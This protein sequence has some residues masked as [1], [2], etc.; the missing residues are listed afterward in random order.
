MISSRNARAAP[1]GSSLNII[2][3]ELAI[4]NPNPRASNPAATTAATSPPCA[5]TPGTRNGTSGATARIL[6]IS[7]GYVAPTTSMQFPPTFHSALT[8]SRHRLPQRPPRALQILQLPGSRIRRPAQHD[9]HLVLP[10]KKRRQRLTPQVRMQ[11]H[12]IKPHRVKDRSHIPAIRI[13]NITALRIADRKHFRM[14]SRADTPSSAQALAVPAFR[15][16]HRT[17]C[18]A[19]RPPRYAC[20]CS[21]IHRLN[22]NSGHASSLNRDGIRS[23]S[24]SNPTHT[25]DPT[26]SARRSNFSIPALT[27]SSRILYS[28]PCRFAHDR[29]SFNQSRTTAAP[30]SSIIRCRTAHS[31]TIGN[32]VVACS[33]TP[34][35]ANI[36]TASGKS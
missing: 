19:C 20:V 6:R 7:S 32:V 14:L 5:P 8:R 34:A 11:R 16:P 27:I 17:P 10:L 18:S 21:I 1:A 35:F 30:A 29:G 3:R 2:P 25:S 28:N 24:G 4:S 36:S 31:S 15:A 13:S 23:H 33:R 12:R 26:A 9:A 22:A